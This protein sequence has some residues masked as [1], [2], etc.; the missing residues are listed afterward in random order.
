MSA[1][2]PPLTPTEVLTS[3]QTD[4]QLMRAFQEG[5]KTA[6]DTICRRHWDDVRGY[7]LNNIDERSR[8][9][10][11]DITQ[12]VFAFLSEHAPNIKGLFYVRGFLYTKPLRLIRNRRGL[13]SAHTSRPIHNGR[14]RNLFGSGRPTCRGTTWRNGN[15]LSSCAA[16]R[17]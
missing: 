13:R 9:A 2:T 5:D 12:G 7:V 16:P 3:E 8:D 4:E 1:P 6:L 11:D 10:V 14:S 17:R 15:G